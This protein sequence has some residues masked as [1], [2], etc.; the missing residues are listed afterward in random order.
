MKNTQIDNKNPAPEITQENTSTSKAS[1]ISPNKT[2]K[3]NADIRETSAKLIL[4]FNRE[5]KN[6]I[7][8]MPRIDAEAIFFRYRSI[9]IL[10]SK[11]L[12]SNYLGKLSSN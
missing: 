2:Q 11:C 8:P 1:T 10:F 3:I 7:N 12:I 9:F 5:E 4:L 6:S